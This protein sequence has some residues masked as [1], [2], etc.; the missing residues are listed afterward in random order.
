MF[1]LTQVWQD[2]KLKPLPEPPIQ[3]MSRCQTDVRQ[4]PQGSFEKRKPPFTTTPSPQHIKRSNSRSAASFS[5]IHVTGY[6]YIP[7][8]ENIL[9][10]FGPSIRHRKKVELPEETLKIQKKQLSLH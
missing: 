3:L 4:K 6:N 7:G 9:Q 1:S 2:H 5:Q 10:G 8:K